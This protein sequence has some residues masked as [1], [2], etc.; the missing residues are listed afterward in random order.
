VAGFFNPGG[1]ADLVIGIPGEDIGGSAD[2]GSIHQVLG[3]PLGIQ[4]TGSVRFQQGG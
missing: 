2:A 3:S 1:M 4:T